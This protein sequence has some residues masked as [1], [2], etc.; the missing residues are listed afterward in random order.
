MDHLLQLINNPAFWLFL[1][2]FVTAYFGYK[3]IVKKEISNHPIKEAKKQIKNATNFDELR[4][5]VEILQGELE[6]KDERHT[7]ELKQYDDKFARIDA[8]L[9]DL[10]VER[11]QMIKLL[12]KHGLNWPPED[13]ENSGMI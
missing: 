9:Q 8:E 12:R 2:T 4:A 10:Y 11:G 1:G 7:L 3:G 6:K 5:V 13:I